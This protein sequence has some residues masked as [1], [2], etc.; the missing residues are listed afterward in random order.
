MNASLSTPAQAEESAPPTRLGWA[1]IAGWSLGLLGIG[2]G[3]ASLVMAHNWTAEAS[4][5]VALSQDPSRLA[6]IQEAG[7]TAW[8]ASQL[9]IER[10]RLQTRA[11]AFADQE[12]HLRLDRANNTLSLVDEGYVLRDMPIWIGA[13]L[14]HLT[15]FPADGRNWPTLGTHQIQGRVGRGVLPQQALIDTLEGTWPDGGAIPS[16]LVGV[17]VLEDGTYLYAERQPPLITPPVRAG[18]VLLNEKDMN[19]LVGS[20]MEDTKVYVW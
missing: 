3:I 1:R 12:R 7:T 14:P 20:L 16:D 17:L 5:S 15:G 10:T 2:T 6:A 11:A 8:E 13:P 19:A 4:L 18:V 9:Q